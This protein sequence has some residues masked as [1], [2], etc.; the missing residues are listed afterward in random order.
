MR[1]G[2]DRRDA[3]A[4]L[5]TL[6]LGSRASATAAA[7]REDGDGDRNGGDGD[8]PGGRDG[9]QTG[10][11]LNRL[12]TTV[13]GAEITG[14][15]LTTDGE[16]FF[17]VQHPDP[18]NVL[19]YD[20]GT[21]GALV[22]ARIDDLPSDFESVQV[23]D[24]RIEHERVRTAAGT[25]QPL[26][27]GGDQVPNSGDE[28]GVVYSA[29]G[30]PMTDGMWPDFNGFVRDGPSAGYLFTNWERSP[31]LVSRLRVERRGRP[32]AA[33]WQVTDA[34]NVD[35]RPV[36]GT[37]TN[38][39]GT[40]SPWGT[41]LTSEEYEPP[42]DVWYDPEQETYGNGDGRMAEY[43]GYWGNPYRYGYIVEITEP[44]SDD[45]TPD[46]RFA[47]GR[48]SHENSVVMPDRRTAYMSDDG[49]GT[50]L[51]KF[52]ADEAGDL[53]SGTLYAARAKPGRGNDPANVAFDIEWV[54][55]AHGDEDEIE[56]WIAEYDGQ[57]E[58]TDA[59]YITEQEV[60]RW[61]NGDA[62]DD[63]VAFLESRKAAGAK[64]ATDEFRKME[65]ITVK[66]PQAGAAEPGDYVYVAMSEVNETMADGEGTIRLQ[67]ND[68]GA[69]YRMELD[70]SFDVSR[71]EPVVT[72]GPN[73]NICGGCPYDARPDSASTVCRSCAFNP[74]H[75]EE[76][77][78]PAES[79][80]AA[81]STEGTGA[82]L[83]GTAPMQGQVD[84]ENAV[85]NPDNLLV[86]SD[87][88]VIIGEDSEF[89]ENN[90]IWLYD[91][92]DGERT[93]DGGS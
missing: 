35:F 17:N 64:G 11:T 74:T 72:G 71:M 52:V 62:A 16:L 59:N 29:A 40:V 33:A 37:W 23:P 89:H 28:F 76:S 7:A 88:R 81:G 46:K 3:V 48:F 66:F 92:G 50:V 22:G 67:G 79:G 30:E 75:D 9:A 44:K 58:S 4:L 39:F 91:P 42:A 70:E 61:A 31:G 55:L 36:E 19:P 45:P 87:D 69:V 65:G 12:A 2:Y 13:L 53:S 38:C 18:D 1:K 21:V 24:T 6:A 93:G 90:M 32:G 82:A 54:E 34:M 57:E 51:F 68:Y 85:A 56:S 20:E 49:T 77:E 27:N 5:T 63:R 8:G 60:R 10:P 73:A 80:G 15:F 26:M 43:L 78:G 47:M 84:P 25:Y 41:P 86:T 14:L 83:L